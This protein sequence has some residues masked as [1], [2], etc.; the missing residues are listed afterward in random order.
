MIL[1]VCPNPSVDTYVY[2]NRFEGSKVNRVVD[3]APFPG[4]KG[5]HV[6]L[7][8][9]ELGEQVT[10]LGFWAGP[11]GEWI[12]QK[13]ESK[14]IKCI[15]PEVKGWSRTCLTF[16]TDDTFDE[17]E[18][19]GK[20]PVINAGDLEAFNLL[21]KDM[22]KK[23]SLVVMSGSWPQGAPDDAYGILLEEANLCHIPVV[24]DVA[25]SKLEK[26]IEK[27]PV[28]IHLN[29]AEGSL[30][31]GRHNIRGMLIDLGRKIKNIA[32]TDG[33]KGLYYLSNH[34][35]LHANV[36]LENI[37]S[38]VGSGDALTAGLAVA[39]FHEY[40]VEETAKL[41]VACGAA[42]CLR[43]ELGMFYKK[44]VEKLKEKVTIKN[45]EMELP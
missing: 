4:G 43:E 21:F 6:A 22:L 11:T 1:A 24:L 3:E 39:M 44:D 37:H 31:T 42:N 19:L 23:V 40:D 30:F 10:L 29:K 20:G 34:K 45:I 12:K 18:I 8:I 32:L 9:N 41:A 2:F 7:G 33:S 38:A 17:T 25:G 35:L 15:G 14:G 26:A 28:A 16:K 13:L 36:V 27:K 5:T